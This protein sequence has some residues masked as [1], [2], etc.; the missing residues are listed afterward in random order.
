[1]AYKCKNCSAIVESASKPRAC[2]ACRKSGNGWDAVVDAIVE[3]RDTSD[4]PEWDNA[5]TTAMSTANLVV[6]NTLT[7]LGG[8]HGLPSAECLNAMYGAVAIPSGG[9]DHN[10]IYFNA[11]TAV[12][13]DTAKVLNKTELASNTPYAINKTASQCAERGLWKGIAGSLSGV[14][15]LAIGQTTRPCLT[16]CARFRALAA[17]K[18]ITILIYFD[19]KYDGLPGNTWLLFPATTGTAAYTT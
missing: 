3:R 10:A 18:S 7:T 4:V 6:N 12:Y 14:A 11:F 2:P 15:L 1:M 13:D 8:Q 19:K 9:S 5:T 17:S 16:C